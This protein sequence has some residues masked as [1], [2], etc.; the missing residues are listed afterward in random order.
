MR[1]NKNKNSHKHIKGKILQGYWHC[2]I[3]FSCIV[4]FETSTQGLQTAISGD[5][6]KFVQQLV[7]WCDS[8]IQT[9]HLTCWELSR[10]DVIVQVMQFSFFCCG[11]LINIMVEI[12]KH[13]S[14]T[15]MC[16]YMELHLK[17]GT[18]KHLQNSLHFIQISP[19]IYQHPH[20]DCS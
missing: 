1:K 4:S 5:L 7:Q 13:T 20:A 11:F 10:N 18:C 8:I 19:Y 2:Q 3:F 6:H 12:F 15:C 14:S 16:V 9:S 17:F